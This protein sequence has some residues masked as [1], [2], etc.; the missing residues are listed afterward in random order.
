[1]QLSQLISMLHLIIIHA[2]LLLFTE[3]SRLRNSEVLYDKSYTGRS[4]DNNI[5]DENLFLSTKEASL[6]E[7]FENIDTNKDGFVSEKEM[8]VFQLLE[9]F[10]DADTSGNMRLEID[11]YVKET[12]GSEKLFDTL[13]SDNNG[14]LTFH[15]F[16]TEYKE[17]FKSFD[18]DEDHMLNFQEF[19]L[20]NEKVDA[21]ADFDYWD[22]DGDRKISYR[23]IQESSGE[24]FDNCNTNLEFEEFQDEL[25]SIFKTKDTD[26]DKE[27]SSDEFQQYLEDKKKF[28]V[29]TEFEFFD[30]NQDE[31]VSRN[32]LF[33]YDKNDF[34]DADSDNDMELSLMEYAQISNNDDDY[35]NNYGDDYDNDKV[36]RVADEVM[37]IETDWDGD[38]RV[39]YEELI[40]DK[41]GIFKTADKDDDGHLNLVEYKIFNVLLN[42]L[43]AIRIDI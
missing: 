35:D 38:N 30:N 39:S 9:S 28:L 6:K 23:E 19:N 2:T 1:M 7:S 17:A 43:N 31:K 32:E 10:F 16:I 13:D 21:I 24:D 12:G 27:L 8:W 15:E 22:E 5:T 41:E 26:Q 34:H 25:V 14:E 37:F 11:E 20:Y 18:T 40:A 4:A 3:C 42:R 29:E 36:I 33:L